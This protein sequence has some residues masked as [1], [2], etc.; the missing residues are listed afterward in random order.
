MNGIKPFALICIALEITVKS[1]SPAFPIAF[2]RETKTFLGEQREDKSSSPV[3]VKESQAAHRT[4]MTHEMKFKPFIIYFFQILVYFKLF[5]YSNNRVCD[6]NLS[7]FI[8]N[9]LK[10]IWKNLD[11]NDLNQVA[12]Q[13][14]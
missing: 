9:V 8:H 1:N 4:F 14:F 5:P 10:C 2:K 13:R 3:V 12:V 6:A 11:K 7:V